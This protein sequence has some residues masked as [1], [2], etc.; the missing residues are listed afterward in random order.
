LN[1]ILN[2]DI[3]RRRRRTWLWFLYTK[4][5]HYSDQLHVERR[6]RTTYIKTKNI[7]LFVSLIR[8]WSL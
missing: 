7:V 6:M 2:T 4:T 1:N 3:Q 5:K 8:C